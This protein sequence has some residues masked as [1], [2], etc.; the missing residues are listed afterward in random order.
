[1]KCELCYTIKKKSEFTQLPCKCA[2]STYCNECLIAWF[3]NKKAMHC[4]SCQFVFFS[5][6]NQTIQRLIHQVTEWREMYTTTKRDYQSLIK[7]YK[8]EIN[9]LKR[10]KKSLFIL[11]AYVIMEILFTYF[12]CYLW[13]YTW[14]YF[15]CIVCT[16]FL[17]DWIYI[18]FGLPSLL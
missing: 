6:D 2:H 15:Y 1:M 7:I 4:P 9:A 18:R 5:A 11:Y 12:I 14:I 8:K 10:K 16:A 13:D 17:L 3:M